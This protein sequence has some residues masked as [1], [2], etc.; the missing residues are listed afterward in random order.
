M[1]Q[2]RGP[3]KLV[4]VDKLRGGRLSPTE[5]DETRTNRKGMVLADRNLDPMRVFGGA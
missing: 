4:P 2:I 1:Y 3:P 5:L